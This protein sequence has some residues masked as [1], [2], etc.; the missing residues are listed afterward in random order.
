MRPSSGEKPNAVRPS[1]FQKWV[2][3]AADRRAGTACTCSSPAKQMKA[4]NWNSPSASA[5]YVRPGLGV[6]VG[7][8]WQRLGLG[9][10]ERGG[11]DAS[12]N[13]PR[14]HIR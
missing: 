10:A 1:E 4:S 5:K 11:N 8:M 12:G 2:S 9:L 6:D 7:C 3:R 13:T 14:E